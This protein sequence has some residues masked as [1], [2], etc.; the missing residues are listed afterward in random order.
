[1][2]ASAGGVHEGIPA[3]DPAT[4]D[5]VV[6]DARDVLDGNWTGRSTIPADGLYPHQWNWDTGFIVIGRS[7]YDQA[8]A[9]QEMEHLFRGQWANGMLPHIVFNP[10]VPADVYFPGPDFWDSTRSPDAPRDVVTSGL[11][12][13]P[14]HAVACLELY[15][16][17][18]DPDRARNFLRTMLPKLAALHR[19][20]RDR[21][22][23]GTEGLTYFLH[24]WESGLDNS[25]AWDEA[26]EG[27]EIPAGALP[28]YHRRDLDHAD[29]RDR[30]SNDAYDRFV[31]LSVVYRDSDYDDAA[32][33]DLTPFLVE[34]PMFNSIWAWSAQCLAEIAEIAG[35]DGGEFA[36]DAKRI[37]GAI[38]SKLW[39]DEHGW[40]YP[41]DVRDGAHMNHYSIVSF[42]PLMAPGIDPGIARRT[43][44]SM[45]GTRHC[46]EANDHLLPSYDHHDENFN[47]RKYWRGP[48][49]INT[50][51]LL[52]R[53]CRATGHHREADELR[54]A[55]VNL[56]GTLGFREY[57]DPHAAEAYGAHR[58]SWTAALAIDVLGDEAP[59]ASA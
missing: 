28:P 17:A 34:E 56:V 44:E 38:Q 3:V 53:G 36:E 41:Y 42:M 46:F 37:T 45:K 57:Y 2:A 6:A 35:E 55:I 29:P 27:F 10:D 7:R 11:T 33:R 40:F 59:E 14:I 24:P 31:Y 19:Y 4:R 15:R 32:T 54:E 52:Y 39:D 22:N 49:W 43:V 1:M 58:F 12:Q 47:P 23:A 20:F 48:V 13:P 26:F 25:P 51:W 9:E 5:R 18:A 8:R 50:D 30:P 21:R 16:H